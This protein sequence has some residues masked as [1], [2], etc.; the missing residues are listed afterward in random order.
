MKGLRKFSRKKNEK[1]ETE[2]R[3]RIRKGYIGSKIQW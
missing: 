2:N 1:V 3:E